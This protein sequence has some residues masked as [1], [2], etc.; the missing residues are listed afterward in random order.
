MQPP[1]DHVGLGCL[2]MMLP[3]PTPTHALQFLYLWEAG[4]WGLGAK[5]SPPPFPFLGHWPFKPAGCQGLSWSDPKGRVWSGT[6][7][8]FN[9]CC[10]LRAAHRLAWGG[11]GRRLARTRGERSGAETETETQTG[12]LMAW[13]ASLATL[14]P[15]H[16]GFEAGLLPAKLQ[17]RLD[18]AEPGTCSPAPKLSRPKGGILGHSKGGP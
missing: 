16:Q 9:C 15:L 3:A 10:R 12:R 1:S 11:E 17:P 18:P 8:P 7:G 2:D 4:G 6:R 5:Q 14:V 13:A